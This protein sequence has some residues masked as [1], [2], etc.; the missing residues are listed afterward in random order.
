MAETVK[1]KLLEV[2]VIYI[3]LHTELTFN[4]QQL[5]LFLLLFHAFIALHNT[6]VENL[7]PIEI[8]FYHREI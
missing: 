8:F 3:N 7:H 1:S 5:Q 2:H 4:P 6:T